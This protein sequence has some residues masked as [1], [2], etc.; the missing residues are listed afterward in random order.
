V[1]EKVLVSQET[2]KRERRER[3]R[4]RETSGPYWMDFIMA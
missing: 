1:G 4:E 3:E 2:N